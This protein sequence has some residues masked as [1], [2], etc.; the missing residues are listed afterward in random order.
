MKRY[1]PDMVMRL[2]LLE[3]W[4]KGIE[5]A[6]RSRRRTREKISNHHELFRDS[7]KK[8]KRISF[9]HS[10]RALSHV[11]LS[12]FHITDI[13]PQNMNVKIAQD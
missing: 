2:Q 13:S 1:L 4:M 9:Y 12:S 11:F 3:R 10:I 7:V 5:A 8:N 6:C